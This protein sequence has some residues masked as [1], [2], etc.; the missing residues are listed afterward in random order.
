MFDLSGEAVPPTVKEPA[1]DSVVPFFGVSIVIDGI[2]VGRI[3]FVGGAGEVIE[4]AD[5]DIFI[6]AEEVEMV[7]ADELAE[8]PTFGRTAGL[9]A[10]AFARRYTPKPKLHMPIINIRP[11]SGMLIFAPAAPPAACAGHFSRTIP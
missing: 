2:P 6:E 7:N 8:I 11:D 9:L 3:V 10:T 1:L 4:L 5:G